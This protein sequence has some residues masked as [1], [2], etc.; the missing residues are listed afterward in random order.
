MLKRFKNKVQNRKNPELAA[1]WR[2]ILRAG[3][4]SPRLLVSLLLR[5]IL[6]SPASSV[7]TNHLKCH[8]NV[9][10]EIF[11]NLSPSPVDGC[12]RGL[13]LR[14]VQPALEQG[15]WKKLLWWINHRCG[16]TYLFWFKI[17]R[18]TKYKNTQIQCKNCLSNIPA[19]KVTH[20]RRWMRRILAL[21]RNQQTRL[22]CW[23]GWFH[24]VVVRK[25]P[26]LNQSH[27]ICA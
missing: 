22:V 21:W 9:N 17:R 3:C 27:K 16:T 23:E 26:G 19:G 15:P 11:G 12:Q 8:L 25:M 7:E 14:D 10:K 6:S 13:Q 5:P 24:K 2:A 18:N 1:C 20:P 4:F